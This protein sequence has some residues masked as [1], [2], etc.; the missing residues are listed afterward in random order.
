M[1]NRRTL[2]PLPPVQVPAPQPID[3][4]APA[5]EPVLCPYCQSA[6]SVLNGMRVETPP[7]IEEGAD[8][9]QEQIALMQQGHKL[10]LL[11]TCTDCAAPFALTYWQAHGQQA[12]RV[13]TDH[14]G[15]AVTM[16]AP[17]SARQRRAALT[18]IVVP[19]RMQ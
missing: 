18:K 12:L 3:L 11:F 14:E 1:S 7:T 8:P 15:T 10:R 5:I 4:A 2:R 6:A 17:M 13:L 9:T 19:G 16:G